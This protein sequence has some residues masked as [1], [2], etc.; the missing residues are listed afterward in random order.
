MPEISGTT[1]MMAIQAV[2]SKIAD[3]GR[4]L[5]D[6]NCPNGAELESLLPGC[7]KAA[8]ALRI[9]YE[10]ALE[11]SSNLAPYDTLVRRVV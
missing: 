8:T 3:I 7:D 9:G 2:E 1:L 5:D 4:R 10:A 11:Q 6:V